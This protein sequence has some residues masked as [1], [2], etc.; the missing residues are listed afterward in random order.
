MDIQSRPAQHGHWRYHP[1]AKTG[2]CRL[3]STHFP[4]QKWADYPCTSMKLTTLKPRVALFNVERIGRLTT[5]PQATPRLRGRAGV[6]RRER[7]LQAHPLCE[8]CEKEGRTAVGS[9]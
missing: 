5:S 7:W 8:D 6:E 1:K 9:E 2:A 4:D 3:A